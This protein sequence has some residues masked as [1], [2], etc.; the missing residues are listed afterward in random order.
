MSNVQGPLS[1]LSDQ[2]GE[3]MD[4]DKVVLDQDSAAMDQAD[5]GVV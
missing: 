1:K 4:A 2:D 5:D 3:D